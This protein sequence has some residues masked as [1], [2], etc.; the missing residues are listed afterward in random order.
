LGQFLSSGMINRSFLI[1]SFCER[2]IGFSY[3]LFYTLL[4]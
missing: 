1:D 3:T 2:I 4:F